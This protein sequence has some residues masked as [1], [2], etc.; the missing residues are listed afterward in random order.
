MTGYAPKQQDEDAA[1]ERARL[2]KLEQHPV[3]N[4]K[5]GNWLKA[6]YDGEIPRIRHKDADRKILVTVNG[7]TF[8]DYVHPRLLH[9]SLT[10]LDGELL[11]ARIIQSPPDTVVDVS[12]R[13]LSQTADTFEYL[14]HQAFE[15]LVAPIR[16]RVRENWLPS[17]GADTV[18]TSEAEFTWCQSAHD[19]LVYNFWLQEPA[20]V[21]LV[22]RGQQL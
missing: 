3:R 5:R 14:A 9:Y 11:Q 7:S 2:E 12:A 22:K 17:A 13:G 10:D 18:A 16:E 15:A 1:W 6:L 21:R 19:P 8:E 20:T 4:R